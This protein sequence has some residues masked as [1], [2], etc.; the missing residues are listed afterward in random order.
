MQ[1]L[2]IMAL[3]AI[4]MVTG[5]SDSAPD[6]PSEGFGVSGLLFNNNLVMY[7]RAQS[8][9]DDGDLVLF[10]QMY[11]SNIREANYPVYGSFPQNDLLSGGPGVDGIPA[12]TRP[13]LVPVSEAGFLAD[14]DLVLGVV[15]A[16]E[17]RAYPENILWWHEIINDEIGNKLFTVSFCPLT[18]TGLVFDITDVRQRLA[19]YPVIETTWNR[20]KELY[21]ESH[22][23]SDDTGV[24]D[25]SRYQSYPYGNYRDEETGPLFPINQ[26]IDTRYLPKH[27]VLGLEMGGVRKAYPFAVLA[28]APV[29]ND[30]IT[31]QAIVVL[32]DPASETA[33]A[34]SR[35]HDATTLTFD[36]MIREGELPRMVDRETG[37]EWNFRGEA[38]TGPLTGQRLQAL[39]A[40]N[41]FWF[42]WAAFWPETLV[43]GE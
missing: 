17:A 35:V 15:H 42:A 1:K 28:A 2:W 9:R 41:A 20:W 16:G 3:A 21:P 18:G 14:N 11:F 30:D 5:C 13:G 4:C 29:I 19:L 43:H 12:I 40:H 39:A 6:V 34:Y 31:G 8:D 26:P 25:R 7:D 38:V 37:S 22:V 24:Y 27:R 10:P 33:I 32:F 23:V 36:A